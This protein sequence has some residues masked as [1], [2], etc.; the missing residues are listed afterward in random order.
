MA[1]TVL[2]TLVIKVD[3]D[4]SSAD[5]GL[6]GL[7]K[8]LSKFK[9]AANIGSSGTKK[10]STCFSSA[11]SKARGA[12]AAFRMVSNTLGSWFKESN[13]Y[14]EV[15]N[16]F[17]VAMGDC[18]ES[19]MKYAKKVEAV[20]DIDLKEWL[21]YQGAFYQLAAGYGIA[22]SSAETMSKNLTQLAYDLSSLWNTDVETAFQKLQSGM[23]GQIKGLKTWGVNVSIAQLRQTA[24]A[25]G[26]DLSTAKMTEAQKATLRY[27]TIMEQTSNAQGDLARTIV[28]PANALRIL[29]AQW[30]QAKRAMGQAV[31]VIAVKVIPWFQALIQII[32]EA[33]QSLANA[34]GYEL[35]E[36]DYSGISVETGSFED[37]SD[38]LGEA[39]ENAKELKKSLLGIDE[40]N[41]MTDNSSSSAA[42]ALGGGYA[43]DFGLDLSQYDYDFLSNVKMPDL[44][45][46]KQQLK[47]IFR[48]VGLI[49][50]GFILWKISKSLIDNVKWLQSIK[51]K[52]FSWGFSILGAALFIADLD[53]LKEYIEDMNENGI[54]FEN[55][56]GVVSEFTGLMGDAL[57]ILGQL[58][59]AGALKVVQGIGEIVSG[60][61]DISESGVNTE[62]VLT[63]TRGISNIGIGI[64]L[65]MGNL[66]LAGVMIAI[67]GLTT[68]I[69]E[70]SSNWDAIKKGDWS[71][72][73]KAT[74]VIGVIEVFGGIAAAL[75]VFT[76]IKSVVDTTKAATAM[77]E[78]TTATETI[79]TTTST[80]T[81][82][83]TSLVK[84]LALGIVVIAE[85]AVAAG[86]IVGAVWGLGLM[87][88][89]VAVAWRPVIDNAGTVGIAMGIGVVLLAA[90]GVVTALLGTVGTT[91]IVNLALGIAMLALLGVSAG[92]FLAE[93]WA[94]GWALQQ[95]G[96]AWYPVIDNGE[97]IAAA[98]GIGTVLLIAI[99][100][101]AALLGVAA[102]ASVGL[103]PLAI[104]LGTAMLLELGAAALLFIAE[105]W[106]IGNALNEVG[107]AWQPV[108]DNGV[109]IEQGISKGTELLIA[110][111]VV[112]AALGVASVASV[113]L[114]PLAVGLGTSLLV[115][116]GEA[117]VDFNKSLVKVADSLSNDLYPSL[118]KLNEKL[119]ILSKDL[120]NFIG[121]MKE[122]A[123]LIV[124]YSKSS[125]I[126]GFSSIVEDIIDFFTKDPIKAMAD[127]VE[128]QYEQSLGLNKNLRLANPELKI[129]ID[130][131]TTYYYFL[132]KL[133]KLT[134][135]TNNISLANGMFV[136]MKSVGKNL[137][138]GFVDGIRSENNTLSRE[139]REVLANTFTS[140]LAYSYGKSF[141]ETLG[142][143]I[144]TGFR[145][146]DFPT[147]HGNVNV[148]DRGFVSL[149]LRA[150]AEGGFPTTGQMFIAREAGPE[151]VGTIGNKSAVVNNEQII[152]GIS[153]GVADAN[154]E[155]NALLRE[156]NNLLRKLLEKDTV[157]NAV[158]GANDI[159]GGL[160]RKNRRDGK[161]V[162]SVGI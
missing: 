30:T 6:T 110:I 51:P 139:I 72:V 117:V 144:G 53:K 24:L 95:I 115:D 33:A 39:A 154:S 22:S 3:S 99:G 152:A 93:I 62:N 147:L 86:L 157:V 148:T 83:L 42:D 69:D 68:I 59:W 11:A 123:G 38:S 65:L 89:Q 96:I 56:V 55:I 101:A 16:L 97:S 143:A 155:Q 61:A 13:D 25:H 116:L 60:I 54:N 2:E 9:S 130:L 124:D 82:K 79:T 10:L 137:V 128:Q 18:A 134:E 31:S 112:T 71:G 84:N 151:M 121:F 109:T 52:N 66:K 104:G 149:R 48:I 78:V 88:Q 41:V 17:N 146:T 158:V 35:P 73:D 32:K 49:A 122:F 74:L 150:Y 162:V 142:N 36:I 135:Q 153:E 1:E 21:T 92:L 45:P 159:I 138:L 91:L 77:T 26:I 85:V 160:Q 47:D 63:I 125:L 50:A 140:N 94:I 129:A 7:Q 120:N 127:D 67:Q 102:V 118:E 126:S 44:E 98:V 58:K 136:S 19:A 76:K 46:Y 15:L 34:L 81:S 14:V 29:Q 64:G 103:L 90:I 23:S 113:G 132:E 8:T 111:G 141:G 27:I 114:L 37:A 70:L 131:I 108:L 87:L 106:A 119:P 161:T 145:N 107:E 156:Q 4:T 20:M 43:S 80:L 40:L 57:L 12:T 133:E 105:I 75:G 5:A 28:T 100:A